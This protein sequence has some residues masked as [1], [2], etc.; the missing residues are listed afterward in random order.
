M[1]DVLCRVAQKI[2]EEKGING[3]TNHEHPQLIYERIANESKVNG[4][5]G[6]LIALRT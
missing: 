2:A 1:S 3:R 5:I 4:S 6:E